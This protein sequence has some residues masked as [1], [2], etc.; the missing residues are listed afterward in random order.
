MG[1]SLTPHTCDVRNGSW[2][3]KNAAAIGPKSAG[4][5]GIDRL[6]LHLEQARGMAWAQG[7]TLMAAISGWIP[8][9]FMTRVRL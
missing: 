5:R 2:L 8:R 6:F 1:F 3:C 7:G 9:M 4:M